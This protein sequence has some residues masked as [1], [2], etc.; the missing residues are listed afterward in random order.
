VDSKASRIHTV[1][2]HTVAVAADTYL[3][4]QRKIEP[5]VEVGMD[6]SMVAVGSGLGRAL[7]H[8]MAAAVAAAEEH[9]AWNAEMVPREDSCKSCQRERKE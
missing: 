3:V 9:Y 4:P 2:N 5:C 6:S 1:V 7:V 8:P